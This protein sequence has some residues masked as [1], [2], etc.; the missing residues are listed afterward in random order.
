MEDIAK[1]CDNVGDETQALD[2]VIASKLK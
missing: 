1:Q 2:E